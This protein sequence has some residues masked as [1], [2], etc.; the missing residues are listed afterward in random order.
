MQPRQ[1][2]L[3]FGHAPAFSAEDFLVTACNAEAHGWISRWPAWPGF[4]LA[5]YGPA[6]SGKSHL[7]HVFAARSGGA[8][9]LAAALR[10]ETL[11]ALAAC[12]AVAVE[13]V[14]QGLDE[15]ALFHLYNMLRENGH[16]LLVSGR[17]APARWPIA[18]PD[19]RSRLLALPV[20]AIGAP[21][22]ALLQALLL[23]LFSDRQL[24][25]GPDVLT[26]LLPRM[27]RSFEAARAL[28]AEIDRVAL[29]RQRAI[30]VPLLRDILPGSLIPTGQ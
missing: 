9:L 20:A 26:Y 1:I 16:A 17:A 27:Q 6:G 3:E 8:I 4:G 11:P 25:V 12:P 2:P 18:L 13:D 10:A 15:A 28:V 30:T 24:R 7:A 14:D 19:L 23:K 22:D 29:A 5:L 21:D